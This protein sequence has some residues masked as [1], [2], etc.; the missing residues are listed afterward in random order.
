MH[1]SP[2]LIH[3]HSTDKTLQQYLYIGSTPKLDILLIPSTHIWN[4]FNQHI[5]F[6]MNLMYCQA[7]S[8]LTSSK[9]YKIINAQALLFYYF[10]TLCHGTLLPLLWHSC[11]PQHIRWEALFQCLVQKILLLCLGSKK[12]KIQSTQSFSQCRR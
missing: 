8:W 11:V 9:R 3:S 12:D 6:V 7:T 1:K 5:L 10:L 4:S 2:A